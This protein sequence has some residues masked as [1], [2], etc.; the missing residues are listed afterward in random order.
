LI[1][2]TARKVDQLKSI[3]LPRCALFILAEPFSFDGANKNSSKFD[4]FKA[5]RLNLHNKAF[6]HTTKDEGNDN[7]NNNAERAD[8]KNL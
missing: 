4:G 6:L 5:A 3:D 7:N 1:G 2:H 8:S